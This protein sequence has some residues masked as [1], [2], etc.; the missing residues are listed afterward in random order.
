MAEEEGPSA[1]EMQMRRAIM[2]IMMD[3]KLTDAEKAQKRQELMC[4]G[5][6]SSKGEDKPAAKPGGCARHLR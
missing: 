6:K 1:A 5:F 2:A 3:T 4:G